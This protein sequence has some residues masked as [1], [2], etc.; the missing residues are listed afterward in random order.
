VEGGIF[1]DI[2]VRDENAAMSACQQILSYIQQTDSHID[3]LE[4][5]LQRINTNWE[6]NGRD[7]QSYVAELEKQIKNLRIM[8]KG[9]NDFAKSIL[10]YVEKI[11]T[12]GSSTM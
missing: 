9:M 7:K 12:T 5:A 10:N 11:K 6:S 8:E 3:S 4:S 1:M 2:Q